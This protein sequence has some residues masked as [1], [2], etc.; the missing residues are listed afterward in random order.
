MSE[1]DLELAVAWQRHLSHDQ[2]PLDRLLARHREKHR[3][4]HTVAHVAWVVR[5]VDSLAA[6]EPVEHLDEI[7]AAAFYHDAVYEPTYPANERAS[8]RLAR[9]DLTALGW[10]A[11]R[12]DRVAAM[13]EATEHTAAPSPPSG[14]T[15]ILIDADLSILGADPAVYSAYARE[16]RSEQRRRG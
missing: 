13:I 11:E 12:A 9:R 8:A 1:P 15:A 7:V 3:R 16:V 4:Y 10:S 6:H 5:H 14:D 2:G